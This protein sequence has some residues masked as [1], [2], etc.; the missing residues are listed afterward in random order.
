MVEGILNTAQLGK[1]NMMGNNRLTNNLYSKAL[2]YLG[3]LRS[4]E[5]HLDEEC[6]VFKNG[7]DG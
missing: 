5:G 4:N 1:L 3:K 6:Q 7:H 2:P